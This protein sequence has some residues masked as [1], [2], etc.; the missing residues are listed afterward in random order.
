MEKHFYD[1]EFMMGPIG[2]LG[3]KQTGIYTLEYYYNTCTIPNYR[4]SRSVESHT[5]VCLSCLGYFHDDI[6][7]ILPSI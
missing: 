2:Q 7:T 4:W 5:S 3:G 6:C 1:K